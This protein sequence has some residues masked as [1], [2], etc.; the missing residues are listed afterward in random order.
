MSASAS[1]ITKAINKLNNNP[2]DDNFLNVVE[3]EQAPILPAALVK[4]FIRQI[5]DGLLSSNHVLLAD[6]IKEFTEHS[7][8]NKLLTLLHSYH[9]DMQS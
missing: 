4:A 1:A 5:P 9:T 3:E 2:S 8:E 6:A 7:N